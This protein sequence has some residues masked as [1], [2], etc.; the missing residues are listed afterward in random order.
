MLK[1]TY[2]VTTSWDDEAQVWIATSDNIVGLATESE[3]LEGLFSN[4][5]EIVPELLLLNGQLH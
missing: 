3:T 4:L 1:P 5:S 2:S